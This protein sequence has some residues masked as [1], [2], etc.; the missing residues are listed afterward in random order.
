MF[1]F[2]ECFFVFSRANIFLLQEGTKE[3]AVAP[4]ILKVDKEALRQ[5]L[6]CQSC[7]TLSVAGCWV[8]VWRPMLLWAVE[9][10]WV[11]GEGCGAYVD[12]DANGC[13]LV[14]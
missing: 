3:A 11:V 12:V 1:V 9:C 14:V 4:P 5:A 6:L 7:L 13:V 10:V 2:F 8:V